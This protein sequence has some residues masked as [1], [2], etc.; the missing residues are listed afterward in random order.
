MKNLLVKLKRKK[1]LIFARPIGWAGLFGLSFLL[2]NTPFIFIFRVLWLVFFPGILFSKIFNFK[3][4]LGLIGQAALTL[5]IGLVFNFLLCFLAIILG[6]NLSFLTI[7]YFVVIG[8]VTVFYFILS[9]KR[10]IN[11][12]NFS[13]KS[14]FNLGNL[15]YLIPATLTLL[16]VAVVQARGANFD[17]DPTYHLAIMRKVIDN[18]PLGIN[19]LSFVKNQ[20]H[21]AYAVLIWPV[22]LS[23]LAKINHLNIFTLWNQIPT[24]LVLMTGLAWMWLFSKTIKNK[25]IASLATCMFLITM[26]YPDGYNYARLPVP[27]SFAMFVLVPL[28]TGLALEYIL[29][30]GQVYLLWLTAIL[31]FCTGLIHLTQFVYFF[32][33]LIS[34]TIWYLIFK[35]KDDGLK[36]LKR[37]FILALASASLIGI[38]FLYLQV[39]TGIL[40]NNLSVYQTVK[41]K[42]NYLSNF[43]KF[44]TFAKFAYLALP[45]TL[46]F[47]KRNPRV[48]IFWSVMFIAPI[49]YNVGFLKNFFYNN[50]SFVF[51]DRLYS[52]T[53]WYYAILGLA[54]GA[55]ILALDHIISHLTK[56]NK[57]F[58]LVVNI[59][60]TLVAAIFVWLEFKFGLLAL[61]FNNL[62]NKRT[63]LLLNANYLKIIGVIFVLA[64]VFLI[65]EWRKK[66][67]LFSTPINQKSLVSFWLVFMFVFWF[68][69]PTRLTIQ[70]TFAKSHQSSFFQSI[71]DATDKVVIA[72]NYGGAD[73]LNFIKTNIPS[74]VIFESNSAYRD[75]PMMQDVYMT[76]WPDHTKPDKE[77]SLLYLA[78]TLLEKKL[79]CVESGKMDYL[80]FTPNQNETFTPDK[81]YFE[82]VYQ[83][84]QAVIYKINQEAIKSLHLNIAKP[85]ICRD[86][87]FN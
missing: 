29:E 7:S 24:V 65:I 38:M 21:P 58:I 67:K 9:L 71:Q 69:S 8:L 40:S 76:A 31:L 87:Q 59:F 18:N 5:I 20:P 78:D 51:V 35:F 12:T 79:A 44:K 4:G 41:V 14:V 22:F 55:V 74:R 75:L 61:S 80:L 42:E 36:V 2:P 11:P 43:A 52:N 13:L 49:I 30:N 15:V 62:F 66:Q 57:Y 3:I 86:Q 37:A 53:T 27:D 10:P 46:I 84:D 45:L 64:I 48:I 68:V 32:I 63:D 72:D 1:F 19:A 50:F 28:I 26:F 54:V 25:T 56:K 23:L 17:F 82:P 73:A 47:I 77:Y 83:T 60:L 6:L 81:R 16:I 34:F 85:L 33:I 70:K 39:Q